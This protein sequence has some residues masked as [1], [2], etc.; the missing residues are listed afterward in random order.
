MKEACN[1]VANFFLWLLLW[2]NY[3]SLNRM[4][5]DLISKSMYMKKYYMKDTYFFN[6]FY[7]SREISY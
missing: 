6:R 4:I 5:G 1:A 7:V 2:W 3:Y